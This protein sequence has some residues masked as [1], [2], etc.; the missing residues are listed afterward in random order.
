MQHV[1]VEKD[2]IRENPAPEE[3]TSMDI[4]EKFRLERMK[5]DI[6]LQKKQ[7]ELLKEHELNKLQTEKDH[8]K[9]HIRQEKE[10]DLQAL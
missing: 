8:A 2:I 6:D 7:E 5:K 10:A 4:E 1:H 3:Q 9:E